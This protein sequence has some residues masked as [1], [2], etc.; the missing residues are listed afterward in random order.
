MNLQ[1][2]IKKT[3]AELLGKTKEAIRSIYGGY[4]KFARRTVF[5]QYK[6]KRYSLVSIFYDR[7]R[8]RTVI[9]EDIPYEYRADKRTVDIGAVLLEDVRAA[10][11]Q[12]ADAL[13]L[14]PRIQRMFDRVKGRPFFWFKPSDDTTPVVLTEFVSKDTFTSTDK[15]PFWIF[16]KESG[17][18]VSLCEANF[19]Y[20]ISRTKAGKQ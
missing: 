10:A 19:K 1:D 17:E 3:D 8:Y 12:V 7:G 15:K 6:G 11:C 5:A 18:V 9:H 4:V 13:A 20:Y 2:F 14:P 16:R